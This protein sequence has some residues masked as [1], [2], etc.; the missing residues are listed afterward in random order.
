MAIA[1]N[2]L[3]AVSLGELRKELGEIVNRATFAGER[4]AVTR[5]GKTVAAIVSVEDLALLDELERRADLE[6]LREARREDDG[7]RISLDDFLAGK[8]L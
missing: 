3:S 4:T 5:H 7:A 8:D 1:M 2:N 6:A